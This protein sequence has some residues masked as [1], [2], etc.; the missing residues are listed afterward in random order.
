MTG[1]G[2]HIGDDSLWK[3][4]VELGITEKEKITI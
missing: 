2:L 3:E 4:I 1:G